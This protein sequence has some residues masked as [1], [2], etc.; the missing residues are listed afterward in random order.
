MGAVREFS[1]ASARHIA[2]V[3]SHRAN[4]GVEDRFQIELCRVGLEIF[5]DLRARRI[6]AV[7]LRYR[8]AREGGAGAIGVQMKAIVM[9]SPD[10]ADGVGLF[11]DRGVESASPKRRSRGEAGRTGADDDGVA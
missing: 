6:A 11:K 10:R 8:Q 9:P 7:S 3:A 1:P 5:D 2:P 4:R